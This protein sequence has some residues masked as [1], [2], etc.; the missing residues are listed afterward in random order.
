V[1]CSLARWLWN[2]QRERERERDR[3]SE[4]ERETETER[5]RERQREGRERECVFTIYS[6]MHSVILHFYKGNIFDTK[7][8]F[9]LFTFVLIDLYVAFEI[10]TNIF[11]NNM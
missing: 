4:T 3:E 5:G 11:K 10:E 2:G 8:R 7:F 1:L 6:L 9:R